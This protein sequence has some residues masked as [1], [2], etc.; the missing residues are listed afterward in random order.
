MKN[1][2]L[3]PV[4]AIVVLFAGLQSAEAFRSVGDSAPARESRSLKVALGP[5]VESYSNSGCLRSEEQCGPDE[6]QFTAT[7]GELHVLHENALYNCCPDDIMVS[8]SVEGTLLRLT[9]RAIVTDGCDCMCC[10]NVEATVVRLQPGTYT[11]EFCW[12]DYDFYEK[13]CHIEEVEIPEDGPRVEDYSNSGCL[14]TEEQC[15]LD[16]IELATEPGT[17]HIL[18][19]NALYNCCPDDIV[20]SVA[21]DENLIMLTEEEIL[22]DPCYCLC[23]YEV[24]GTVVDIPPGAYTVEFCWYDYD[25]DKVRCYVEDI[26]IP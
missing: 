21:V 25:T 20:I 6:F 5:R 14:R 19:S 2:I 22:L 15:G 12:F 13:R 18:H 17:L 9:E 7:P 1:R 16:E 8:L 10:Y 26:D 3:V 24:E 4:C 11:V 23:C